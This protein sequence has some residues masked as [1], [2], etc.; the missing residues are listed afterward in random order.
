MT[1]QRPGRLRGSYYSLSEK[2]L[3]FELRRFGLFDENGHSEFIFIF[4]DHAN[5]LDPSIL[6]NQ[7]EVQTKTFL[8]MGAENKLD[9]R[10]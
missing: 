1:A 2:V 9:F 5:S 6:T 7:I 8:I 10:L 3:N 4:V